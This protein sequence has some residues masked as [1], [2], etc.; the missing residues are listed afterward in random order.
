MAVIHGK[1]VK[2]LAVY[3]AIIII[4]GDSSNKNTKIKFIYKLNITHG[5]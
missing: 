5:H 4:K 1:S 3:T 2:L